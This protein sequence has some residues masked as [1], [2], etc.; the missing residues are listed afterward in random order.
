MVTVT[1]A[2]AHKVAVME[3]SANGVS[4]ADVHIS[5]RS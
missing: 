2:P 1:V 3:V 4:V 5:Q